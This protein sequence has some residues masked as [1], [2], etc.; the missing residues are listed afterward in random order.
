[1]K[2]SILIVSLFIF[3]LFIANPVVAEDEER[4]VPAFSKISLKIGAK[5]YVEQGEKQ[6]VKV[7]AKQSTLEE[8]IT[9][10]KNRTLTIRFPNK[11]MFKK[12][13]QGK[14]EIYITVPDIEGLSMSGSG[15][16]I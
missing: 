3:S 8:L 1:M 12:F 11:T 4:D 14:V 9:E 5:V 16:I 6:S 10:V 13:D 15:D 2:N 7:V